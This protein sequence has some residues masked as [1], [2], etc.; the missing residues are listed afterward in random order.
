MT[1][2]I[3]ILIT[4]VIFIA[5]VVVD[6]LAILT[7]WPGLILFGVILTLLSITLAV[8]GAV[9]IKNYFRKA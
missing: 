2:I 6:G 5:T 7:G 9:D 4:V 1:V 3:G 8:A